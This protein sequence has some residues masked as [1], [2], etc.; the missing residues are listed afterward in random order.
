MKRLTKLVVDVDYSPSDPGN[1]RWFT[2]RTEFDRDSL[3]AGQMLRYNDPGGLFAG[4]AA[5]RWSAVR[6]WLHSA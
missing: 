5:R 6:V 1:S 2:E 4:M 3:E